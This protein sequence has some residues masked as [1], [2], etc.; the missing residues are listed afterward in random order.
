MMPFFPRDWLADTGKLLDSEKAAYIDLLCYMWIEGP[1]LPDDDVRIAKR[2]GLNVRRWRSLKTAIS[3]LL[4][5]QDGRVSQKRLLAEFVGRDDRRSKAERAARQRW[6]AFDDA[7]ASDEH[8]PENPVEHP[9]SRCSDD[10]CLRLA[11]HEEEKGEGDTPPPD[12]TEGERLVL[13]ELR[14]VPRYPFSY[15]SDVAFVRDLVTAYPR[16]NLLSEVR[17]WKTWLLDNRPKARWNPRLRLRNWCQNADRWA[18]EKAT[19]DG[20][21][22]DTPRFPYLQKGART[23]ANDAAP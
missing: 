3:P 6:D 4:L 18:R 19:G 15:A 2:L 5:Y 14:G 1:W 17:K 7:D 20:R 13:A 11:L 23:N 16:V 21:N 22:R 9:S 12:L 10:A 8:H